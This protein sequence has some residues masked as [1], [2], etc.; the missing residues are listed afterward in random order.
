MRIVITGG[1]GFLGL[2]L[3]RRILELR[4]LPGPSGADRAVDELVLADIAFPLGL[5]LAAEPRVRLRQGDL[6]DRS[7]VRSLFDRQDV[8]VFHLA[9]VVSGGAELDFDGA[10]RANLDGH[11]HLLE[12]LRA[13]GSRPRHVFASSIAVYGAADHVSDDTRHTPA[14]T[15]GMTKAAGELLIADYTRKGFV[16]GRSGRLATVI[17]RPGKPNKAASGFA[18]A[19]FREPLA[20]ID[21]TLPVGLDAGMPVIGYR[22]AVDGL[23]ALYRLDGD[24]LGAD[25]ALNLPNITAK[26]GDMVDSLHRVAAERRPDRPLGRIDIAIDPA[27]AAMVA[28]WPAR[29]DFPRA[30]ALGLPRDASLDEIVRAYVRDYGGG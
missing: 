26:V 6:G 8:G 30:A 28:S 9:S 27:V 21:T 4:R 11:R 23:L 10:L 16:D 7:F 18:S 12:A 17:V 29:I 25:R 5:D 24:A 15:Y 14:T 22:T 19:V 1:G 13:L 2:R 3:A 20:G